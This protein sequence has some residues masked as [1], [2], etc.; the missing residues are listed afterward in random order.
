MSTDWSKY[1]TPEDTLC[2]AKIPSDNGVIGMVVGEV[3]GIPGLTVEHSSL[4]ENRSHT[5]VFGKKDPE[6]RLRLLRICR[7]MI[8][9]PAS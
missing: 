2:R 3:R 8:R 9:V 1:A 7:W 4:P 5:D 6:V